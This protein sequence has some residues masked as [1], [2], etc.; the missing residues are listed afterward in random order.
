MKKLSIL[1]LMLYFSC[2]SNA[3]ICEKISSHNLQG[4]FINNDKFDGEYTICRFDE[5]EEQYI[6]QTNIKLNIDNYIHNYTYTGWGY[7]SIEV[8][9]LGVISIYDK[10]G[11]MQGH[12]RI[13]YLTSK[14]KQLIKLGEL[15]LTYNLGQVSGYDINYTDDAIADFYS[16]LLDKKHNHFISDESLSYTDAFLLLLSAKNLKNKTD[17]SWR[18]QFYTKLQAMWFQDIIN[19]YNQYVFFEDKTLCKKDE[20]EKDIFGCKINNNQLSICFNSDNQHLIY[21]FGNK[22]YIQL[23]LIK[24]IS[25]S[26]RDNKIINFSNATTDYIID[27]QDGQESLLIRQN[28]KVINQQKCLPDSIEP[29]ILEG[30]H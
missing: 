3:K 10:V 18:K 5:P 12:A 9:D 8:S 1:I 23:A 20:N 6:S 24:E 15:N 14:N 2:F 27:T 25:N 22:S 26:D 21:R 11:G 16:D 17:F 7:P 28:D 4:Q 19:L 29:M 30:F 13:I